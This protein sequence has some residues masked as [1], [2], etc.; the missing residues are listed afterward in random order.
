[1]ALA[2]KG[3]I[4]HWSAWPHHPSNAQYCHFSLGDFMMDLEVRT[5]MAMSIGVLGGLVKKGQVIRVD[6]TDA[7]IQ[8]LLQA[9]YLKRTEVSN[10]ANSVDHAGVSGIPS[11]SVDSSVAGAKKRGRPRKEKAL[12]GPELGSN[13]DVGEVAQQTG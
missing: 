11:G 8:A 1:M 10:A 5:A 12:D 4:N 2:R 13:P 9:G 3:L 7:R 6:S